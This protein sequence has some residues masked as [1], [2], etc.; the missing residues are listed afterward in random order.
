MRVE[1]VVRRRERVEV[2]DRRALGADLDAVAHALE[3]DASGA[4]VSAEPARRVT[5]FAWDLSSIAAE[6]SEGPGAGPSRVYVDR[7][8]LYVPLL[9]SEGGQV[10]HVITDPLGVPKEL[11]DERGRL[12]WSATH[13]AWGDVARAWRPNG[14]STLES[15]FRMLGQY[16]DA[17]TGLSMTRFRYFDADA[18][19]WLSPDPLGFDGGNNAFAFEAAPTRGTDALGLHIAIGAITDPET[20]VTTPVLQD[21]GNPLWP[22]TPGSGANPDDPNGYGRLGDSENL[23][24]GALEARGTDLDGKILTIES[25]S[26]SQG[27]ALDPCIGNLEPGNEGCMGGL[28]QFADDF[29]CTIRYYKT[30]GPGEYEVGSHQ[31]T[32]LF[33]F[34]PGKPPRHRRIGCG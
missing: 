32:E 12:A 33:E 6:Q 11:V 27:A 25:L 28:Q 4:A 23:M 24:L 31:R 5:H 18:A 30:Q 9:Q 22:N 29:N 13:G 21:N 20:G 34:Q 26:S 7:P 8:W 19:R 10:Y 2:L 17:E 16:H 3:G 15:P 1:P 14:G